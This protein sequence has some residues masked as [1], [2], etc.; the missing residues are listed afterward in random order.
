LKQNA[1]HHGDRSDQIRT[2]TE[3]IKSAPRPKRSNP[4]GDRSEIR[5]L[6]VRPKPFGGSCAH[7]ISIRQP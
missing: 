2:A 1:R 5:Q 3:A 6:V 7:M 4:H